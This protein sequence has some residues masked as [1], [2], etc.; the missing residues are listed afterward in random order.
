MYFLLVL[1]IMKQREKHALFPLLTAPQ[2]PHTPLP[3]LIPPSVLPLPTASSSSSSSPS[4][5]LSLFC[6]FFSVFCFIYVFLTGSPQREL[7]LRPWCCWS[8]S[9][10]FHFTATERF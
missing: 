9:P 8:E 1:L 4:S 3:L 2:T 10:N 5:Q 6:L 7:N